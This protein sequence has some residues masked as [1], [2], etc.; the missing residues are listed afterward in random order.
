VAGNDLLS[1]SK[2]SERVQW[3]QLAVFPRCSLDP[4]DSDMGASTARPARTALKNSQLTSVKVPS[5][6]GTGQNAAKIRIFW[7]KCLGFPKSVRRPRLTSQASVFFALQGLQDSAQG[8][9]PH[10]R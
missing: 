8:F 2:I 4:N 6:S 9:I 5:I 1:L 7:A 3:G 10:K